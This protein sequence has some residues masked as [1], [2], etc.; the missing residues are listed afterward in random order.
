MRVRPQYQLPDEQQHCLR[1]V[2]RL[3]WLTIGFMCSIIA[4]MYVAM[5]SSQ[6][7]KAALIEDCLSLVPPVA[8]LLAYRVRKRDPTQA[9]PYGFHRAALLAFLAAA[10]AI[11]LFGVFIV[12]DSLH[13]LISQERPTLGHFE[14]LGQQW[15]IW[16]GWVMVGALFY[17]LIPP[18]ILGRKK[19]PLATKLHESTLHADA[20][21]NKADWLTAAAGILGVLGVG[22]GYWWADAVAAGLIGLD[23]SRDGYHNVRRAMA[24]LMDHRPASVSSGEPLG[25][26]GKIHAALQAWPE[27]NALE[28]RLREEGYIVAGE[29]FVVL[30][31]SCDIAATVERMASRAL[32]LDWRL[33]NLVVMPVRSLAAR[34]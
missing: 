12:Y 33:H 22:L 5:G 32:E 29:I 1:R 6:A 18:M 23:V 2:I 34:V 10:V 15:G 8:F 7:M 9:F 24:D 31:P 28:V 30:T 17:S 14:F 11:L 13:T 25:L 16:S 21:M 27:V 4:V 3:E 19:L 26:E 20:T